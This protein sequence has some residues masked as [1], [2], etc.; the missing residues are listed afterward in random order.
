MTGYDT[1]TLRPNMAA[2]VFL[3]AATVLS[4]PVEAGAIEVVKPVFVVYV[5]ENQPL[6]KTRPTIGESIL[7]QAL[8]KQGYGV[9]PSL[10]GPDL[11]TICPR[12]VRGVWNADRRVSF[13]QHYG[14]ADLLWMAQ[15]EYKLDTPVRRGRIGGGTVSVVA[16]VY[17]TDTGKSLWYGRVADR[18]L[19][20]SLLADAA[21]KA[22]RE[23]FPAMVA[24]FQRD[25]AVR[26]WVPSERPRPWPRD[27]PLITSTPGLT[28]R[29][30]SNAI[31]AAKR[32][33]APPVGLHTGVVVEADHLTIRP[34]YR[35]GLYSLRGNPV[36]VPNGRRVLWAD[37]VGSAR[38]KAGSRPLLLKAYKSE[39]NRIVLR[40][41]DVKRLQREAQL[42][43]RGNVTVV[44]RTPG[45]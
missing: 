17:A 15:V 20:S 4:S 42:L 29:G 3:A 10:R 19:R 11:A 6:T 21:D 5:I 31:S 36:F 39:G 45:H 30:S 41:N 23:V 24:E 35:T 27:I 43:E 28:S 32:R 13:R 38:T 26:D 44:V 22:L 8:V 1:K 18:P 7:I 9:V 40:D 2:A 34:S 37:S 33:Q 16:R 14:V 25:P 12:N